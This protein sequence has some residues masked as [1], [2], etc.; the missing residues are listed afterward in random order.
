MLFKNDTVISKYY[1]SAMYRS[2]FLS[3]NSCAP[4]NNV[5]V[6]IEQ[7]NTQTLVSCHI[8]FNN[9]PDYSVTLPSSGNGTPL[10]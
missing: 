2:L 9:Y 10:H 8:F 5:W 1:V 7:K 6:I 4:L 3:S